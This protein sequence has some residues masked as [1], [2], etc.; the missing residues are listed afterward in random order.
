ME[1]ISPWFITPQLQERPLVVNLWGMTG[2][3]KSSLVISLAERLGLNEKLYQY[4]LGTN[5]FGYRMY[6]DMDQLNEL[7][8]GK[9]FIVIFDEF[10]NARTID[11][12]SKEKEPSE[13]KAIWNFI[14]S[15]KLSYVPWSTQN[16][17]SKICNFRNR[18]FS[19]VN[20]GIK[21][22]DGKFIG[23]KELYK[24][25]M[26]I[27]T[28]SDTVFTEKIIEH[29]QIFFPKHGYYELQKILLKL[30]EIELLVLLDDLYQKSLSQSSIDVSKA[31]V[32][33]IGNLDEAFNM[34]NELNPDIDPDM[35]R[36]ATLKITIPNIKDALQKR[37]R[38]EQIARLGNIHYI[39]P[40]LGS[41]EYK[42]I[43]NM[44]I[45][46]ITNKFQ[47]ETGIQVH[48]DTSIQTLIF[49]EGVYPVQ[50]TRPLFSTLYY[51]VNSKLGRFIVDFYG[52]DAEEI[53]NIFVSYKNGV[54]SGKAFFKEKLIAL[55]EYS[56][57]TELGK[58]RENKQDDNQAI[59]SVHEAGHAVL[60]ILLLNRIPNYIRSRSAGSKTNG[61]VSGTIF[62]PTIVKND[63][64]K[65]IAILLGGMTAEQLIFGESLLTS[66][67]SSDI[68]QAT[69]FS[70]SV[71]KTE[72]FSTNPLCY[73]VADPF[74]NFLFHESEKQI[75]EEVKKWIVVAKE[76]ANNTLQENRAFLL[77]VS[78][79]L[80]R[81]SVMTKADLEMLIEEFIPEFVEKQLIRDGSIGAYVEIL[82]KSVKKSNAKQRAIEPYFSGTNDLVAS[83]K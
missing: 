6:N 69:K 1:T 42:N 77:A 44:K 59:T 80:F 51:L 41:K 29:I 7:A 74:S 47:K 38:N 32:F 2:T 21:I 71:A 62:D 11:E 58:L 76:L 22:A 79:A 55:K 78:D 34:N 20:E 50:G 8:V 37:F 65:R 25:I 64:F 81:K 31:L 67:S 56:C 36:E 27:E 35:Y 54:M 75:E 60:S 12:K 73:R 53:D 40:A 63:V 43:I 13:M 4:D 66:G 45:D 52:N 70:L 19:C 48:F 18:I 3:G 17:R 15:G 30:N 49:E 28:D 10:Q 82:Q 39:Y 46:S 68:E 26:S 14:D 5:N 72:G 24:N 61:F 9:P 16:S 83:N 23:D 57:I 33:V